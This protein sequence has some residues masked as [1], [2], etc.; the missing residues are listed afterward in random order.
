[1]RVWGLG[2]RVEGQAE[3]CCGLRV[4]GSKIQSNTP[5]P[6]TLERVLKHKAPKTNP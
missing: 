1:M 5:R 4:C 3:V 6:I 2:F